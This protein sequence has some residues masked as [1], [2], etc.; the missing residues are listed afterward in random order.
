MKRLVPF[1]LLVLGLTIPVRPQADPTPYRIQSKSRFV[2]VDAIV[3]D[4]Q[5]RFVT[6]LRPGEVTVS[7][8]G[9]PQPIAY[10]RLESL[11]VPAAAAAK[12][13][14]TT[15]TRPAPIPPPVRYAAPTRGGTF[16]I[17]LDLATM[18]GDMLNQVRRFVLDYAR[19]RLMPGDRVMLVAIDHQLELLQPLTSD[20]STLE[21]ALNHIRVRSEQYSRV[22]TLSRFMEEVEDTFASHSADGMYDLAAEEAARNGVVF[23][24]NLE[25][26]LAITTEALSAVATHLGT[27]PGRKQIVFFSGGYP[28]AAPKIVQSIIQDRLAATMPGTVR[29]SGG[30]RA[31]ISAIVG[32][33]RNDNL[34][35]YMDQVIDRANRSQ[36]AI[37]SVDVRGLTGAASAGEAQT[38]MSAGMLRRGTYQQYL[39]L[40]VTAPQDLL[41]GI[42]YGTGALPAFNSNDLEKGLRQA[43]TDAH[44]YYLIGYRSPRTRSKPGK[45][46]HIEVKVSRPGVHVRARKGYV[47]TPDAQI[48][49]QDIVNAFKFPD[50]FRQF[51]LRIEPDSRNHRLEVTTLIPTAALDFRTDESN[52]QSCLVEVFGTLIKPG[53]DWLSDK[54]VF[55]K[56]YR[57]TVTPTELDQLHQRDNITSRLDADVP[58]GD[59]TLVMVVRQGSFRRIATISQRIHVR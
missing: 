22:F 49:Q 31:R 51:P 32:G 25:R 11:A 18:S 24:S 3:V 55:T 40:E 17:V 42:S 16:A 7:E 37:Y 15:T 38:R 50:L 26:R 46:H 5:G 1:V 23:I 19:H 52:R 39:R 58:P 10:F 4:G 48:L 35:H 57:L 56:A 47:E 44:C 28:L 13:P 12:A 33:I 36:V 8:D 20:F 54:L 45:F 34:E 43:Y 14:A 30:M 53:G 6:D 2:L 21:P 27:L 29:P 41:S 59:Y 9:H